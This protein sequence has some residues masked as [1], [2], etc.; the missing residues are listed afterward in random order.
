[1][2]EPLEEYTM[3]LS[4]QDISDRL[5]I[6]DLLVAYGYAME[7]H[8]WDALDGVFTADAVI[9]YTD[10]HGTR[11]DLA[12]TKQFMQALANRPREAQYLVATSRLHIDGNSARSRTIGRHPCLIDRGGPVPHVMFCGIW[13]NDEFVRTSEGWRIKERV[14]ERFYYHNV[15]P[16]LAFLEAPHV[17]EGCACQAMTAG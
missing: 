7:S 4:L 2:S 6:Q 12:T 14:V 1:M 9:D 10:L 8:D 5:E 17:A 16:E 3:T 13:Y 11:G 15:P